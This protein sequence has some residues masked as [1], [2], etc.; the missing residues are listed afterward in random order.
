MGKDPTE[1]ISGLDIFK[2]SETNL[3]R[4]LELAI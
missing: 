2:Q 1:A 3:L 4:N